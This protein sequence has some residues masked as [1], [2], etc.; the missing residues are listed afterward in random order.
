M[1]E[2]LVALGLLSLGLT[3]LLPAAPVRADYLFTAPQTQSFGLTDTDI[4]PGTTVMGG[5][6]PFTINQFDA[7]TITAPKGQVAVLEG[8]TVSLAY[9]FENTIQIT[10]LGSAATTMVTASGV[11]HLGLNTVNNT[12][13][14]QDIVNTPT[15]FTSKTL[16]AP[17]QV[18]DTSNNIEPPLIVAGTSA[19]FYSD[20]KTLSVFT[21][22]GTITAP[23][24]A[25]AVS[26]FMNL[27][28]NG[29]G[30]SN[31]FASAALSVTYYY[32]FFA[33]P[34]PSS[35]VLT[36]LGAAGLCFVSR[37]RN[38]RKGCAAA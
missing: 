23:V 27:A 33:V 1:R 36:G 12:V 30:G 22:N 8:V 13:F 11:M 4:L 14:T 5:K 32:N 21:G 9:Q 2:R 20:A 18:S 6:D 7:S 31:T 34:E 17:G 38:R 15:F 29:V 19:L 16:S 25:T 10:F 24:T 37:A 35:F 3:L 28:G 26:N